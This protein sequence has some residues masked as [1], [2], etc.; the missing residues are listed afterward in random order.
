MLSKPTFVKKENM[1]KKFNLNLNA[2]M[3]LLILLTSILIYIAA[4]GWITISL[5]K[6]IYNNTKEITNEYAANYASRI[7]TILERDLTFVK[8][9]AH[10]FSKMHLKSDQYRFEL[11][12]D[13]YT[14][15]LSRNPQ[16]FAI[17]DSWELS[18]TDT[19]WTLPYG[20]TVHEAL[21]ENERII[22]NKTMKSLDG[23][24]GDYARIKRK[25]T[26]AIEN[27]YF[28][29]Y[30]GNVEDN[31][32]MTSLISPILNENDYI[33]VVGVD[34]TLNRFQPIIDSIKP[35]NDINSYAYLLS[36][37]GCIIAHPDPNFITD[38]IWKK[39]PEFSKNNNIVEN[40][41]V[42]EPFAFE[43][44]DIQDNWYFASFAPIKIGNSDTP[45]FLVI[46]IPKEIIIN[47]ANENLL[48]AI[49]IGIVGL[50]LLTLILYM[51][52]K[53]I[54]NPIRRTTAVLKK[55]SQGDI[56][57]SNKL[58]IKSR[59]EIGQ[60]A[61]SVNLLI[62]NLNSTAQFAME[63]G[64]GNLEK[65]YNVLGEHDILG[66]SLLEMRES[67]KIAKKAEQQRK[68][69]EEKE[70][71]TTQGL[72]KFA[73][74]LRQNNDN[75]YKLS[76][77]IIKNIVLYLKANQGGLFI[78]NQN[79]SQNQFLELTA[80]MAY[81]REKYLQ[82][83][84]EIG[85]GLIGTCFIEKQSIYLEKI[86]DE[87]LK[88]TSG[89]GDANPNSLLLVPLKFNDE[90][91]GVVE[92]A[93]FNKFEDYHI[94]FVEAVGE[95][96]A[97]TISTVKIN[98]RTAEL[99]EQSQQQSEEMKAQEEEMRQNMEELLATQEQLAYKE[100]EQSREIE[101]LTKINKD[102]AEKES[103]YIF[104][105]DELHRKNTELD[106][107][108]NDYQK[109]KSENNSFRDILNEEMGFVQYDFNGKISKVNERYCKVLG[110]NRNELLGKKMTAIA[111]R[112]MM[113][114][115][116]KTDE[117]WQN[118]KYGIIYTGKIKRYTKSK[119][120]II[121]ESIINTIFDKDN[122]PYRI[123]EFFKV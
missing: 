82:K 104:E 3:I 35:F 4:I 28:Y 53:S 118:A 22:I 78:L 21:Y 72:A 105:H 55:L 97:S 76:Y 24:P 116:I 46:N 45:W 122:K 26:D 44:K 103:L 62:D 89:L 81:E 119:K 95:S 108:K 63:I 112:N 85:D 98:V 15:L 32:I 120:E 123:M 64:K 80:A 69:Q 9:F 47:E 93:S 92:I 94:K 54:S 14:E 70:N 110:Y 57:S 96:I 11:I 36:N 65:Q 5:R 59:D 87:Y 60:M 33:G 109:L 18:K 102:L 121:G 56:S 1:S 37:N 117:F 48:L 10:S 71:W 29:S 107:I 42:G 83:R 31:I 2:K 50:S 25:K 90:V 58:P 19:S 74:I 100:K 106:Q 39:L 99:L 20:R 16:F 75:L 73:D 30:T 7:E 101:N 88:I 49:I 67:L 27:P 8:S 68:I 86:P 41:K 23:D 114:E 6:N 79:D 43:Y 84:V 40:M 91:F 52:S 111:D 13:L 51:V 66:Q 77:N 113:V 115:D 12:S 34:I 38:T 17:W 61:N